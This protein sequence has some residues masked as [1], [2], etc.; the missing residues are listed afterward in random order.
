MR[1]TGILV[2]LLAMQMASAP[3][4]AQDAKPADA[5]APKKTG[6]PSKAKSAKKTAEP[7]QQAFVAFYW[8]KES[9]WVPFAALEEQVSISVDGQPAGKVTQG[10][11]ISVPVQPGPHTYSYTRSTQTSEGEKK[12]SV[13]VPPGQTVYLETVKA[14][15]GLGVTVVSMQQVTAEHATQVLPSLKSPLQLAPKEAVSAPKEAVMEALAS[16]PKPANKAAKKSGE[17][18]IVPRTYITFYWPKSADGSVAF[19][20][21]KEHYSIF[22]DGQLAGRFSEGEF[23]S[24]EVQPGPHTYGYGRSSQ[25]GIGN[26]EYSV[27][28][29]PGQ[30]VY[31]EIV[32]TEYGMVTL[33]AP[34]QVSAEQAQQALP[35]LKAPEKDE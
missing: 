31:F 32:R 7:V 14:D 29:S 4:G 1:I 23:I 13:E 35:T 33:T 20:S 25:F 2:C 3:C 17:P 24:V 19:E 8:P 12:G 18:P 10:E 28:I 11:F 21:L 5:L 34:H 6:T 15:H 27:D 22:I 26:K 30:S 16:N 9:D